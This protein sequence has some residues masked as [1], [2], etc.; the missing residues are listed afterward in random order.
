MQLIVSKLIQDGP[1]MNVVRAGVKTRMNSQKNEV[2][3]GCLEIFK[4][5]FPVALR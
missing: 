5:W 1:F 2:A 3:K 4:P